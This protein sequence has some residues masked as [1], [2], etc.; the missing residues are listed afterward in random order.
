[1]REGELSRRAPVAGTGDEFDSLAKNINAMLAQI[2]TL[3]RNLRNVSVGIAHELRTPLARIQNRLVELQANDL[4]REKVDAAVA[5]GLAEIEAALVTFDALLK[6]GQIEADAQ[7]KGF[8]MLK[9]SDLVAE[10]A[11]VYEPVA[12]ESGKRLDARIDADVEL[13][14][15]RALLAQ[16]ISNLLENAIEH[17]PEGTHI[18][19][20]L[21]ATAGARRLVVQDDGP[22][23][24]EA[25]SE[26]VF[27]RFYRLERNRKAPGN[28]LGLSLVKS[29]CSL[30]GFA[31]RLVSAN[32][33]A[34]FEISV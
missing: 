32:P 11:E 5:A 22:G 9:L 14:G 17:T 7:R 23:I 1:M 3:T 29:I 21:D 33:G 10:L 25:D 8:E 12:S 16:M 30:H 15:N 4:P 31:I 20:A 24:P 28:G 2:E 27:E 19:L 26:Q 13:V 34:R 18:T 6:I